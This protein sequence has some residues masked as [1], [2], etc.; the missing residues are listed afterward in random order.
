[1][2]GNNSNLDL[3]NINAYLMLGEICPFVLKIT[4]SQ[5]FAKDFEILD[6]HLPPSK[7]EM[8]LIKVS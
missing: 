7:T 5:S 8:K 6:L 4:D 2:T 1:M 3:V